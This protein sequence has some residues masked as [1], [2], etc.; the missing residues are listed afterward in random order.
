ML[1]VL[2]AG[3]SVPVNILARIL[4]SHFVRYELAVVLSHLVG[5]ITAYTL[6]RLFVFEKSGR[7]MSSELGRFALVN[8]FSAA[9]TWIVSVGLVN[10]VFPQVGFRLQPELTAHVIGLGLASLTSFI[11][12][13]R[14]SFGKAA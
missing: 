9:L 12:H 6:T 8:V 1:F 4:I 3:A 2:A 14:F 7:S 11:G 5:M 13:S 10:Y